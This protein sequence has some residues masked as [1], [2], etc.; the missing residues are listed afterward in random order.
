MKQWHV[1]YVKPR[2]EKK[3]A[4]HCAQVFLRYYLPLRKET[5]VFQRR[6]V[7]VEKAVFPGY[8]FAA[9]DWD[10]RVALLRSNMIVR[11]LTPERQRR[12]IHELVQVN[13]VLRIDPTL[14]VAA[15]LK[16]GRAVRITG[17]PFCGIE[18]V[19]SSIKGSSRVRLNVEMVA[20]SLVV[21][22]DREFLEVLD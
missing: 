1:L 20:Q 8:L 17:G 14:G 4:L 3:V 10:D 9:F 2:C 6:R 5:K 11:I 18:G 19:V 12:F 21:E 22:V 13:R 15:K 16:S 7:T